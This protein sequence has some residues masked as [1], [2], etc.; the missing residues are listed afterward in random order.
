MDNLFIVPHCKNL[1][2]EILMPHSL[3]AI[4]SEEL[5]LSDCLPTSH[6][7]LDLKMLP[8]S[9][10]FILLQNTDNHRIHRVGRVLG[11]P[12]SPTLLHEQGHNSSISCR[13]LIQPGLE[14]SRDGASSTSLGNLC[15]CLSILT[16]E[17]SFLI[18]NLSL[19]SLSLK[20]FPLVLSQQTLLKSLSFSFL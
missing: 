4:R 6:P 20:P 5:L 19:P 17:D 9:P 18:S 10:W 15:G 14:A 12:S 13:G 11:R 3:T 16:V 7:A 1:C 8:A 2:L